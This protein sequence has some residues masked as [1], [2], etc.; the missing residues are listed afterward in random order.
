MMFMTKINIQGTSKQLH[1]HLSSSI[2]MLL[3]AKQKSSYILVYFSKMHK[4]I[5]IGLVLF[6]FFFV[7]FHLQYY[8]NYECLQVPIKKKKLHLCIVQRNTAVASSHIPHN[9]TRF[10]TMFIVSL[11]NSRPSCPTPK[12]TTGSQLEILMYSQSL[13]AT[14]ISSSV[15]QT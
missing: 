7:C 15:L 12:G 6:A 5:N 2:F 8:Y 4:N 14:L 11:W 13:F 10:T 1:V 3:I 9:R